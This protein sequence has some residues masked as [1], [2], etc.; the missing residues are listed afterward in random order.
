M[1]NAL[2]NV[3]LPLVTQPGGKLHLGYYFVE[4]CFSSCFLPTP[5]TVLA[6]HIPKSRLTGTRSLQTFILVS[7]YPLTLGL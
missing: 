5:Q 7:E 6:K 2:E 1:A 4:K 3:N